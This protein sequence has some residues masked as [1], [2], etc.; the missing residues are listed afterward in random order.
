M[1]AS[2]TN[3]KSLKTLATAVIYL[4]LKMSQ[5][6]REFIPEMLHTLNQSGKH[7]KTKCSSLFTAASLTKIK[8]LIS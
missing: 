6:T 1:A 4:L 5:N 2:L 7:V 3:T 8:S